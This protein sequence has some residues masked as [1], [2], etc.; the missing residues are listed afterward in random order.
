[1]PSKDIEPENEPTKT[2]LPRGTGR[3]AGWW[4]RRRGYLDERAAAW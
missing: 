2:T 4:L 1:V 3:H